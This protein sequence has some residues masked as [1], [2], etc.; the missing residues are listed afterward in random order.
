MSTERGGWSEGEGSLLRKKN[1]YNFYNV[2][3]Y[4]LMFSLLIRTYLEFIVWKKKMRQFNM[5]NS[6]YYDE[7]MVCYM[8]QTIF[9]WS[10]ST[11]AVHVQSTLYIV[12]LKCNTVNGITDILFTK[13]QYVEQYGR[14]LVI[15]R[16]IYTRSIC[17]NNKITTFLIFHSLNFSIVWSNEGQL[18]II[19][20]HP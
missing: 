10:E 14:H 5:L 19:N 16:V 12:S 9:C 8:S 3:I 7:H 15:T 18:Y 11:C 2:R 20:D 17:W 1:A 6:L 13:C 4:I